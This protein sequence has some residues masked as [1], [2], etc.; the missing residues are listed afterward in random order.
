[1]NYGQPLPGYGMQQ[2]MQPQQV[3]A[4]LQQQPMAQQPVQQIGQVQLLRR[5]MQLQCPNCNQLVSLEN[6]H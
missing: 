1:M 3:Q 6:H 5:P 4:V 2:P